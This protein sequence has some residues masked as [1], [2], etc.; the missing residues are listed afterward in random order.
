MTNIKKELLQVPSQIT[1][2]ET[3]LDK[4]LKLSVHTQELT[5]SDK[6]VLFDLQNKIGWFVFAEAEIAP[7]DLV[8]LPKLTTEFKSQKT[9]SERLRAILYV[10]WDHL[11]REKGTHKSS[12]EFY[13]NYIE[14][15]IDNIKQK[16]NP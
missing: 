4:T 16:I 12:D 1:K 13:R 10:W 8:E 3:L 2:V 6:A 7:E 14:K 9:P 15:I 5:A 11:G